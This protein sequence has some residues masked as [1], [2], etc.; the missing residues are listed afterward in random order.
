MSRI[1]KKDLALKKTIRKCVG[2]SSGFVLRVLLP[3][4]LAHRD[5]RRPRSAGDRSPRYELNAKTSATR[6][7]R[8]GAAWQQS[9]HS[10]PK[11]GG[12]P[13]VRATV[14]PISGRHGQDLS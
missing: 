4:P 10:E 2:F 1:C 12:S 13:F 14:V 9:E 7:W 6:V 5:G 8:I 11:S 3:A